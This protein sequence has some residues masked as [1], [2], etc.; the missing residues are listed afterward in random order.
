MTG[1]N[2]RNSGFSKYSRIVDLIIQSTPIATDNLN[3]DLL[4]IIVK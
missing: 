2:E 3:Y 1:K 4:Y